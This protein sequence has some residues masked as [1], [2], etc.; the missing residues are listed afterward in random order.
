VELRIRFHQAKY[1][2]FES[3]FALRGARSAPSSKVYAQFTP[4]SHASVI[5]GCPLRRNLDALRV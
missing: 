1:F 2:I 3:N 4:S 5:V